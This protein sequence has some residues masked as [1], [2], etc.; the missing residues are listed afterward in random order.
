MRSGRKV[1]DKGKSAECMIT[2]G[3]IREK[4]SHLVAIRRGGKHYGTIRLVTEGCEEVEMIEVKKVEEEKV[5]KEKLEFKE[6]QS[7]IE[8]LLPFGYDYGLEVPQEDESSRYIIEQPA[9]NSDQE[10]VKDETIDD[11]DICSRILHKGTDPVIDDL[12]A[13]MQG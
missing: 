13:A 6:E 9:P 3:E 4:G 7:G 2:I 5:E 11:P 12:L 1:E 10:P 8:D